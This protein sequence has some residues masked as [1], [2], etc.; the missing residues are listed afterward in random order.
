V[1]A[2][3]QGQRE[4]EGGAVQ[5]IAVVHEVLAAEPE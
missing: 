4:G 2:A 5:G 1:V 3:G